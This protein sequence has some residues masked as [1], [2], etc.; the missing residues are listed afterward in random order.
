MA[1]HHPRAPVRCSHSSAGMQTYETPHDRDRHRHTAD[2]PKTRPQRPDQRICPR[3]LTP[4]RPADHLLNP[5]FERDRRFS[6][7][8]CGQ[9]L[10]SLSCHKGRK[11]CPDM[12]KRTHIFSPQGC[13]H[14]LPSCSS[15]TSSRALPLFRDARSRKPVQVP[16]L[17][18]HTDHALQPYRLPAQSSLQDSLVW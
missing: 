11:A 17:A 10:Q 8:L 9:G 16:A 15:P 12:I 18:P 3:R 7:A 4:G 2:P 5:I 14:S 1:D 13:G 6:K